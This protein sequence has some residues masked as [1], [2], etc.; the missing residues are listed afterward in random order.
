MEERLV[1]RLLA[2]FDR[3]GLAFLREGLRPR[4]AERESRTC[5]GSLLLEAL[6][7]L[8]GGA[9][10]VEEALG[11]TSPGVPEDTEGPFATGEAFPGASPTALAEGTSRSSSAASP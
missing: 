8:G 2:R 10:E 3:E 7:A 4:P 1:L 9:R 6:P 5:S 11:A